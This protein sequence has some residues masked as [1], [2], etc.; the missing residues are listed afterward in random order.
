MTGSNKPN[1]KFSE[2]QILHELQKYVDATYGQHYAKNKYQAS[3]FIIDAGYGMPF[4]LGNVLK[5]AQ[6]VTKKGSPEDW[7]KDLFKIIH[8]T[9]LAI[10]TLDSENPKEIGK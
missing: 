7:R 5:Y 2:D 4:F 3:E 9:M 10:H 1:Y 8:Y 6:R